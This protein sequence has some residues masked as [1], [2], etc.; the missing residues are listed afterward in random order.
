MI[1]VVT[2][3]IFFVRMCQILLT[4]NTIDILCLV[5][6]NFCTKNAIKHVNVRDLYG[7]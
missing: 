3:S 5:Y 4:S 6:S 2:K 1:R 7:I